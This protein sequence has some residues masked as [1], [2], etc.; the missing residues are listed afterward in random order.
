MRNELSTERDRIKLSARLARW[1]GF[2][3]L[4]DALDG[5]A[6]DLDQQIGTAALPAW[7]LAKVDASPAE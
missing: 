3:G 2:S 6:D 5:L 4:A 7:Q 1:N